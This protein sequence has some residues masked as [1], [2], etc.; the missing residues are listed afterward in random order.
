MAP[1]ETGRV[2]RPAAHFPYLRAAGEL[3]TKP[4]QH[5]VGQLRA[6]GIIPDILV[7][8]TEKPIPEEHLQKLALFCNVKRKSF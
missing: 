1:P 7:C 4:S 3:K 5:S 6:I 2:R 8:R